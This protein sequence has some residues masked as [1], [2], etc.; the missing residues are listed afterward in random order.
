MAGST[1]SVN[2]TGDSTSFTKA[3]ET[4]GKSATDFGKK[5]EEGATGLGEFNEKVEDS[6]QKFRGTADLVDG[7]TS[8]LS[9]FGINIPGQQ[10]IGLARGLADLADGF[11]T[12][13]G[14]ALDK[15]LQKLGLM[16]GATEAETA[17][18]GEAEVAQEGLNTAFL[19]SP[20]GLILV[21]LAALA[22]AFYILWQKSGT[23][24]DIVKDIGSYLK[25]GFLDAL[26]GIVDVVKVVGDAISGAFKGAF[27]LVADIWNST[28][29]Q[30]HF[31]IPGWVPGIGGD[32]FGVPSIPHFA[33]GGTMMAGGLAMVGEA[34]REIVALPGGAQVLDANKTAG[35]MGQPSVQVF[36]GGTD[37]TAFVTKI[38]T[39]NNRAT[40]NSVLAGSRRT[41]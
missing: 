8:S 39:S 21:G 26:N 20:I 3:A 7:V 19:L 24:R 30:L 36:S 33:A 38:I 34:G 4:A 2:I 14:P 35:L 18:T 15:G 10:V 13:L 37:I 16:R 41:V 12:V 25:T 27:N 11:S 22:A 29:G 23:F 17:A 28:V 5:S 9:T 1:I 32:S 6:T 31:S 40:R